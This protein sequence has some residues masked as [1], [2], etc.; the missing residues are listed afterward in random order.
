MSSLEINHERI[1]DYG[2]RKILGMN[3]PVSWYINGYQKTPND[4]FQSSKKKMSPT[5]RILAN[6]GGIALALGGLFVLIKK[7]IFHK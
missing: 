2:C 6:V 5:A 7:K 3:R 1:S 4:C